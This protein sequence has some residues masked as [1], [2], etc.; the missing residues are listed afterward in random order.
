MKSWP[1]SSVHA[2]LLL[3]MTMAV[4]SAYPCSWSPGYF[5]QLTNLRGTVVGANK[6]DI[7]HLSRWWR[8]RVVVRGATLTLY[9]YRWPVNKRDDMPRVET[10]RTDNDGK[11]DFGTLKD[12]HYMLFIDTPWGGSDSYDVEVMPRA[13]RNDSVTIDISPVYPDCSGGH[14]F[15]IH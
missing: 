10:V 1:K 7:R 12:G 11:F 4:V 5:H 8:Q 9:E 2:A 13:K 14:E 15:L 3:A 6:G